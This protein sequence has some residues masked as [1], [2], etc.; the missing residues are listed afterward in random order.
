MINSIA[1]SLLSLS[2]SASSNG[3]LSSHFDNVLGT[4]LNEI[5]SAHGSSEFS[6]WLSTRGE[7]VE[8]SSE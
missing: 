8:I 7:S 1:L 3:L 6:N 5:L 2:P 4:R